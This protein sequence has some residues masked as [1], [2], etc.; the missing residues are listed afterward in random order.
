[1]ERI[2][3]SQS[4]CLISTGEAPLEVIKSYIQTQGEKKRKVKGK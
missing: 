3:W 1:M 4:Y 2:L